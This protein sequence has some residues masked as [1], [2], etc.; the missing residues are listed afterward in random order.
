LYGKTFFTFR[1]TFVKCTLREKVKGADWINL[2]QD[3]DN[4]QAVVNTI[5]N[6]HVP[7]NTANIV[8]SSGTTS[9]LRKTLFCVFVQ[10]ET[11]NT[12]S[13]RTGVKCM[14]LYR[15]CSRERLCSRWAQF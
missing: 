5:M 7:Y 10:K 6:I 8:S 9:F 13:D 14:W 15:Y 2:A 12:V 4:W 3:R 11:R 1:K